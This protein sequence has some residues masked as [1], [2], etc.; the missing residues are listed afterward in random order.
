MIRMA[1]ATHQIAGPTTWVRRT[2][3][4][5][6]SMSHSCLEPLHASAR[7]TVASP[8]HRERGVSWAL[9]IG[10][11]HR[12]PRSLGDLRPLVQNKHEA[13]S[14]ALRGRGQATL[15]LETGVFGRGELARNR[16]RPVVDLQPAQS[17][18]PSAAVRGP[19]SR[20][21]AASATE[22]LISSRRPADGGQ[23]TAESSPGLL[24][25]TGRTGTVRPTLRRSPRR[26]FAAAV[27]RV[28]S[29]AVATTLPPFQEYDSH[30]RGALPHTLVAPVGRR[31]KKKNKGLSSLC[32]RVVTAPAVWQFASS[33]SS[34]GRYR[35]TVGYAENPLRTSAESESREGRGARDGKRMEQFLEPIPRSWMPL[36]VGRVWLGSVRRLEG[37]SECSEWCGSGAEAGS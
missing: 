12:R 1:G 17:E 32:G 7:V 14:L 4:S 33:A 35:H 22:R 19:L 15:F 29:G 9:Q 30:W 13:A 5:S 37:S 20:H 28:C 16:P 24:Q 10:H 27:L 8:Q 36:P 31:Q 26:I 3:R 34:G 21:P 23:R 18:L 25:G 6:E 11:G 2:R